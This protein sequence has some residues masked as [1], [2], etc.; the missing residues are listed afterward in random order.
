MWS[1]LVGLG[2][3]ALIVI[4]PSANMYRS[5]FVDFGDALEERGKSTIGIFTAQKRRIPCY[6]PCPDNHRR[7]LLQDEVATI[8]VADNFFNICTPPAIEQF[9]NPMIPQYVRSKGG[10]IMHFLV[11]AYM[12]LGLSIVC[13]DYFVPALERMVECK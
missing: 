8:D 4:T 6:L 12:F 5:G 3:L 9:P 7:H 1:Y 2:I 13:D 11:A 10:L